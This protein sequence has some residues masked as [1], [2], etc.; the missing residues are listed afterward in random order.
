METKIQKL[1]DA[2][3]YSTN[4]LVDKMDSM[5]VKIRR[6]MLK[7]SDKGMVHTIVNQDGE[8]TGETGFY[9]FEE[10]DT[11]KFAK[12]FVSQLAVFWGLTNPGIR[13][14]TYF[15]EKLHPNS[16]IV[17]FDVKE[18]MEYC[19]YKTH[20]QVYKGL[21]DLINNQVLFRS[22]KDWR[23]FINPMIMFNGDRVTFAKTYIKKKNKTEN[24][25]QQKISFNNDF[26]VED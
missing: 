10:V 1:T 5:P 15:I 7:S 21:V 19:H 8:I 25:N 2:P 6:T 24:P 22:E 11:E 16:D 12:V 23:Y 13:V 3:R 18:C 9:R 17:Y 14:L 26:L 4:P 20:T